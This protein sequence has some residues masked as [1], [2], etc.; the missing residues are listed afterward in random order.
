MTLAILE[1]RY[2]QV[3]FLIRLSEEKELRRPSAPLSLP[4]LAD[5]ELLYLY[6]IDG[7]FYY[8]LKPWLEEKKEREVVVIEESLSAL[9]HFLQEKH[10]EKVL[11]HPQVHLRILFDKSRRARFLRECAADFPFEKVEIVP[12]P[13]Y[14]KHHSKEFEKIRLDLLRRT[15]VESALHMEDLHYHLFFKNLLPNFSRFPTAFLGDL[16][17][18]RFQN[19]P[20]IIC[21]AGPSLED[22]IEEL[23][24][25]ENRALILAG[26][27]TITALS[28][29][30]IL[31][32]LAFAIDPN[33]EEYFRLRSSLAF[34][35]P[36]LYGTRVY[37]SI[38]ATCNGSYGYL[39]TATGGEAEVWMEKKLSVAHLPKEERFDIEAMSV[40]TLAI[41]FAYA[42]GCNPIIL[43][44]VDLAYI[45]GKTYA[46]GVTP[47][48]NALI[49]ESR[50]L[51][52]RVKREDRLG[53]PISTAVKW[54]MESASI[55]AF[56][57]KHPEVQMISATSRGLS[58]EGV[59]YHPLCTIPFAKSYD[60]RG[61]VHQEIE[62]A[63][64]NFSQKELNH[65]LQK[66]RESL[67]RCKILIGKGLEELSHT[68][69]LSCDPE[70][71]KMIFLQMELEAEEAYQVLFRACHSRLHAAFQRKY[72]GRA[73]QMGEK[74]MRMMKW[75]C[76][77]SKW[78]TLHRLSTYYL[79]SL[80]D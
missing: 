41:Q 1:K 45:E 67:G 4:P 14:A 80:S 76:H 77:Q 5:V 69:N 9:S 54:I 63:K 58:F 11:S 31:P 70:T 21:G 38:F 3:A 19:V 61:K 78:A 36:L 34:E 28:T 27:S 65:A 17:R 43:V 57:K 79:D 23:K 13:F 18:G 49:D 24:K 46:E 29:R 37:P 53:R 40:T 12:S 30:G 8:L 72:R 32:H 75:R 50:I 7:D 26:G 59:P 47:S 62:R 68:K 44:G 20:A 35:V 73:W 60:M 39:S 16:F 56:A 25:L 10:A 71:G 22:E 74:E 48:S 55:S 6:G 52:K 66:L 64:G 51:E 33:E 42:L 2:P 15:T